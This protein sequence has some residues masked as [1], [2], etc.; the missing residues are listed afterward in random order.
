MT[1]EELMAKYKSAT[2]KTSK[3][4]VDIDSD[5]DCKYSMFR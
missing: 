1:L 5:D 2:P 3:M 4:E